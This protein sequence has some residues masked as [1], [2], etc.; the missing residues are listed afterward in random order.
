MNLCTRVLRTVTT[1]TLTYATSL[2]IATCAHAQVQATP[3]PVAA[4]TSEA[5]F[6][7]WDT[8][9]NGSLS[10]AEFKAGLQ[11]AQNANALRALHDNFIA[12]DS[13]RD[14]AL[15]AAE[16]ANLDLIKK[17]GKAAPSL[18]TFDT[19]K[20]QRLDFKEYVGTVTALVNAKH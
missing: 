11:Q 15:D 19:D 6:A 14:N 13:N 10:L 5:V 4:A 9:H 16:Y 18:S 8:D 12:H 17:A 3:A 2:L 7:R 1:I 20:N